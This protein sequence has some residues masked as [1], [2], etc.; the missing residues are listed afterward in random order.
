[1]P[2]IKS[3]K[4]QNIIH[5]THHRIA[6]TSSSSKLMVIA[7]NGRFRLLHIHRFL[8]NPFCLFER[9]DCK[10]YSVIRVIKFYLLIAILSLTNFYK[11]RIDF[12]KFRQLLCHCLNHPVFWNLYFNYNFF[13]I[14]IKN[15]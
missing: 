8:S 5:L 7:I 2:K 10:R 4:A 12:W 13:A 1:M 11:F 9:S 14:L 6:F 15:S 3:T